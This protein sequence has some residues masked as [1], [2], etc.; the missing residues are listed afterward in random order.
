MCAHLSE[1]IIVVG[2]IKN[3]PLSRITRYPVKAGSFP[4]KHFQA[5]HNV[6]GRGVTV[7]RSKFRS[8]E[9]KNC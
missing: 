7:L 8:I 6:T 3:C 9:Q 4:L 2:M 1:V 5:L